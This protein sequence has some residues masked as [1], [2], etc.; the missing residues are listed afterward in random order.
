[1]ADKKGFSLA[2][3][4]G[5]VCQPDDDRY[6]FRAVAEG[7]AR[8]IC[9]LDENISTVIGIEGK[10][11]SGK[12]SLLNLLTA[13]LRPRVS[14]QTQ[15][16]TFSPWLNSPDESPVS[17]FLMNIAARLA[18]L[19]TSAQAQAGRLS[20]LVSDLGNYARQTSRGL[21]PLAR[22]G[23]KFFPWMEMVADGMEAVAATDLSQREKTVSELR[24][25]I[26]QQIAA[27]DVSFIVL[28]DDLDRLEPAQAVEILRMVRSVADFSCFRY[29]MCYDRDVLAHAVERGL[30]VQDGRLYLQKIIPLSFGLPRPESF[31]LRREFR[32]GALAIWREVNEGEPDEDVLQTLAHYSGCYGEALSTPREVNQALNAVRFRYPGLR[33]YVYFPDLCLI[34]LLMTVNPALSIWVEHYLT[35]WSVVESR[36]GHMQ[37]DEKAA[38]T[39]DLTE[40][41]NKFGA[42]RA[43]SVWEIRSWLPGIDGYDEQSVSLFNTVS[44][45][46]L[47]EASAQRRLSS[48]VYWRY[49]FS[50]SA[51][52]NVM[53]DADIQNLLA[54][55]GSDYDALERKL[56]GSVTA[57]GVSSRTW[58]EH[59]LTR[60]TPVITENAGRCAQKNLL[61]F[62]FRRSDLIIPFYR[63]RDMLFR[64]EDLGI[65]A[66]ASQLIKQLKQ[67]QPK[68]AMSYISQ[69]FREAEAFAWATIYLSRLGTWAE[70]KS[71]D[72]DR[73][74]VDDL[75]LMMGVRLADDSIRLQQASI[76]YL[77]SFIIAWREIASKHVVMSWIEGGQLDDRAYLQMLLNFRTGVNSS[78]QGS[79]L[80]LD[81]EFIQKVMDLDRMKERLAD[82]K[83]RDE[84]TLRG[85]ITEVE[86][87]IELST[88]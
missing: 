36:D 69:L 76:P 25:A 7:L 85:M 5:P 84:H 83:A 38:I 27:L 1:M 57:N 21:S 9:A 48:M 3:M 31:D 17:A 68:I 10:W 32:E 63:Q 58:F 8:S 82:I 15:I 26:E 71:I 6:G 34:Q 61:K 2:G 42:I 87:A 22:L 79:Y 30:G 86:K 4:E 54:L 78:S 35:E 88:E 40:A 74:E 67:R 53:S 12:S 20:S 50:F 52:Q 65:N 55:A 33:D 41:L 70:S 43:R 49:Y 44:G 81:L 39:V 11:G 59:I 16:V 56:M 60:L 23:S 66:L 77:S 18:R 46:D 45:S 62:L 80:H 37:D 19:D 28:I 64:L 14:P 75:R 29:V 47:E 13:Q 51:P 73:G 24:T 72:L